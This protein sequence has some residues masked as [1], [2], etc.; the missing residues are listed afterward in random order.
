VT[1]TAHQAAPQPATPDARSKR[2]SPGQLTTAT[3]SPV[4]RAGSAVGTRGDGVVSDAE[5]AAQRL[6]STVTSAVDGI[7]T[8]IAAA[9]QPVTSIL[10]TNGIPVPGRLSLQ[11]GAAIDAVLSRGPLSAAGRAEPPAHA[12][13]AS[14]TRTDGS[15]QSTAPDGF[16]AAV[17]AAGL[18]GAA[19]AVSNGLRSADLREM[20]APSPW[21]G[22]GPSNAAPTALHHASPPPPRAPPMS[23]PPSTGGLALTLLFSIFAALLAAALAAPRAGR[24]AL[25][26]PAR[27]RP[28][29][30]VSALERPG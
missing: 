9:S 14:S 8:R 28:L 23:L 24:E 26:S 5:S 10:G 1:T 25:R 20:G 30:F 3:L 7:R 4:R 15:A 12:S 11:P 13:P 16:L 22:I 19:S 6:T 21:I 27:W 18:A 29:R 17:G 2:H